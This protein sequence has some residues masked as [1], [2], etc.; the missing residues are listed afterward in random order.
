MKTCLE[1]NAAWCI[2]KKLEQSCGVDGLYGAWPPKRSGY[3]P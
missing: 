2:S 1:E 3:T